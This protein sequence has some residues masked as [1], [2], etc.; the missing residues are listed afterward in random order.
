MENLMKIIVM[1]DGINMNQGNMNQ[2]NMNQGNINKDNNIKR[3]ES[4]FKQN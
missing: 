2:G 4:N 1:H 3:D